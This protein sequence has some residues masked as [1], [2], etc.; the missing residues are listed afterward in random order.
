MKLD[1]LTAK[2]RHVVDY[3]FSYVLEHN[4]WPMMKEYASYAGISITA[5]VGRMLGASKKGIMDREPFRLTPEAM[6]ELNTIKNNAGKT[7]VKKTD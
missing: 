4:K 3:F 2:Q 7:T 6:R 1:N 5:G